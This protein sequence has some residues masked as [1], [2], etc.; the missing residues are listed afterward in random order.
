[1]HIDVINIIYISFLQHHYTNQDIVNIITRN[2]LQFNKNRIMYKIPGI[3]A[4]DHVNMT[5]SRYQLREH[6]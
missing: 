5:L 2:I 3:H 4:Y 1:M 6:C